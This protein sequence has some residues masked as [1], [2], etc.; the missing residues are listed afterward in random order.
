MTNLNKKITR[1]FKMKNLFTKN[2]WAMKGLAMLVLVVMGGSVKGQETI[3]WN[4][5][6]STAWLT[7]S[8]W[9]PTTAFAGSKTVTNNND[10]AYFNLNTATAVGINMTTQAGTHYLGALNFGTSA[11]TSRSVSNSTSTSGT[12]YFNGVSLN[13]INNSIIWNQS[14]A[15]HTI[16]NGTGTF[17]LGLNATDH[18]IQIT[19][20]G[21]I[22]IASVITGTLKNI[23]KAGSGSGV[24]TLSGVNTYSGNTTI[25]AGTLALSTSGSISNSPNIIIG[26]SGTFNVSGLTTALSLASSQ[27]LKSSSNGSNTTGTITVASSKNLTLSSGGLA[28]TA[29]GGG[30]TS[31]LTVTSASG[32]ALAL[33]SAP[34]SVTTTS[35]LAVGTYKLIAKSGLATGVSGTIGTLTI[36]GS[37]LAANTTGALSISSG[38]LILTVTSAPLAPTITLITSSNQQLSVAFTAGSDGNSAITS[39]KYSTDGG[40]NFITRSSGTTASP[41]VITTLSSDGT[42]ALTNGTSYNVQIQAVNAIGDGTATASTAATPSIP[43]SYTWNESIGNWATAASWTPSRISPNT[44][45]ILIFDGN[46]QAT[47]SVTVDFTTSESI[48]QIKIQNNANVTLKTDVNRTL[49][50]GATI[51][52]SDLDIPSGSTLNLQSTAATVGLT[53][54]VVTG[55]TGSIS[56]TVTT[57]TSVSIDQKHQ[58]KAADVSGITFN[59]G[60]SFTAGLQSFSTNPPFGPSS[61]TLGSVIFANGS[62][63]TQL[64]G[65]NPFSATAPNSIVTFNPSSTYVYKIAGNSAPSSGRTFGNF[66]FDATANGSITS[67]TAT[68]VGNLIITSGTFSCAGTSSLSVGGNI[69]IASGATL[70]YSPAS[71]GAITLNGSTLKTISGSGTLTL[72]SNA[73][74]SVVNTVGVTFSK[75]ITIGT[76]GTFTLPASG[77][78]VYTFSAGNIFTHSNATANTCNFNGRSITLKSDATGTASFGTFA[79]TALNATNITVERYLPATRRAYRFLAAP[80]TTT[81]GVYASWQESG[82]NATG[83]GLQV[84]GFADATPGVDAT[85]GLDKSLTGSSSMFSYN[86]SAWA[87]VTNTKTTQLT[88]GAG[89]R[90]L[91][92]GDRMTDLYASNPI[93]TATTIRA[94]GTVGQGTILLNPVTGFNLLGNPYPSSINWDATGWQAARN[95]T[96]VYDAIYIYDP[97][98]VASTSMTY[99]AYITGVGGTNGGSNI[100]RSGQAF[101]VEAAA[102]ASI[103]FL[104]AYKSTTVTGGFFRSALPEMMRVTYMQNNE[105]LD[106]IIIN[107]NNDAQADFDSRFD[108]R[109]MGG[110]EFGLASF[111]NADRL[112]IHTR[113]TAVGEDSVALSV[114]NTT[115][116]NYQLKF[117]EME[118]FAASTDITLLDKFLN[119]QH[120]VKQDSIVNFEITIDVNSKGDDRFWLF[121]NHKSTGINQQA[122]A[123]NKINVYP[124]PASSVIN[125]SLKLT[126]NQKS[127][128]TYNIYNQLGAM[129]QAGEVDFANG[130]QAQIN[131]DAFSPGVYFITASNGKDLQTIKFVK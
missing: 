53:V 18:V 46:T 80:V 50:I 118:G 89:F 76:A 82:T 75:N 58:L 28:F 37:G 115:T 114:R 112:A 26:S 121:Y 85:S 57:A 98:N 65:T 125:M 3:S 129:V 44:N 127:T 97:A 51:S 91:V 124:N 31:P 68:I 5:A 7:T 73:S 47:P 102:T 49:N 48:G 93:A 32:G 38:E 54:N 19:G 42:T 123:K 113:P 74:I 128:Y 17:N 4:S 104:E 13:S 62:T 8:N 90:V 88:P 77:S 84:T 83:L 27:T 52:G 108:A 111:K 39:Y 2:Y 106:E 67:G 30:A 86:G 99:P 103:S 130:K 36:Y 94:T 35:V 69:T 34:I 100:I 78:G 110:D 119:V 29:Y 21:G 56:G 33:N 87:A 11:T 60:G 45:D 131:I 79:S 10:I 63:F 9:S 105:H 6:A 40:S 66:E 14:S 117:S 41:I 64:A 107:F 101:F 59:S 70:N 96:N 61:G 122:L 71:S 92:R 109:S 116:G 20:I 23:E 12:V 1:I 55:N 81:G 95:L 15:T 25:S 24:L 126:V 72:G 16:T 43:Q 120:N 22:T